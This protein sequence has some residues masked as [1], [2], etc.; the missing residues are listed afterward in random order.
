MAKGACGFRKPAAGCWP[1]RPVVEAE[2]KKVVVEPAQPPKPRGRSRKHPVEA[3][4][5]PP[6]VAPDE[7]EPDEQS[8]EEQDYEEDPEGSDTTAEFLF[9]EPALVKKLRKHL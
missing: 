9:R 6:A 5:A 3:V 7:E 4:T 8:E 2:E 1:P